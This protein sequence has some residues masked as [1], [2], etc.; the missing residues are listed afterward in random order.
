MALDQPA[1]ERPLPAGVILERGEEVIAGASIRS[2]W[3]TGDSVF[4]VTN[5]RFIGDCKTGLFGGE[6]FDFPL[7]NVA[8][9]DVETNFSV[10]RF[11]VGWFAA[12]LPFLALSF[13]ISGTLFFA[14]AGTL[15]LMLLFP[16][17][18]FAS[19]S[20]D[21]RVAGAEGTTMRCGVFI[22][23]K[24]RANRFA[25]VARGEAAK[26]NSDR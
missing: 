12:A 22:F 20:A 7:R 10:L 14:I 23:Q 17:V 19:F 6:R 26:A 13:L 16:W 25:A 11:A 1:L 21:I 9:V 24:S 4:A 5:R 18:L 3:L 15:A 8:S 2:A